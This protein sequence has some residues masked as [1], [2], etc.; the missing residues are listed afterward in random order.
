MTARSID[1]FL[2]NAVEAAGITVGLFVVVILLDA[3]YLEAALSASRRRY[4]QIQ[5]SR[6]G[7]LLHAT[8]K[9]DIAWHLPRPRWLD[10]R[11]ARD[12]AQATNAAPGSEK[13]LMFVLLIV[14]VIVGPLFASAIKSAEIAQPLLAVVAWLTVLLSGL[15][16]FDFRG[17]LDHIDQS[18][19][20]PPAV[21]HRHRTARRTH[22]HPLG[23]P[24]PSA[25]WRTARRPRE[26]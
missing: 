13:G 24:Y 2:K 12:F 21:G 5:R 18:S 17:D 22:C 15:L 7:T 26:A 25:P 19:R 9:G 8:L 10:R 16:K 1:D 20:S 23:R 4:A 3:N 11:R 14:A 6:S